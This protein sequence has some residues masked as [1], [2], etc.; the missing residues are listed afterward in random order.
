MCKQL[1]IQI[2]DSGVSLIFRSTQKKLTMEIS[3]KEGDLIPGS[4]GSNA[5]L[6]NLPQTIRTYPNLNLPILNHLALPNLTSPHLT[7]PHLTSP[8]LT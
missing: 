7:S 5:Y 1:N 4:S 6:E 2:G 8:H 3:E